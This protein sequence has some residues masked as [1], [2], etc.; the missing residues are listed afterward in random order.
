LARLGPWNSTLVAIAGF[1]VVVGVAYLLLPAIDEV[2]A[3]FPATLLWRF[4]VASI[5]TQAVLWTTFGLLFG[6]LTERAEH[7]RAAAAE[8]ATVS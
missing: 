8:P 4:R 3:D 6:A 1:L 2:P 7:V 5:G